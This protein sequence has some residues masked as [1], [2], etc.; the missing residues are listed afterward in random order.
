MVG[1]FARNQELIMYDKYLAMGCS[2]DGRVAEGECR[3]SVTDR[4][5][6]AGMSWIPDGAKAMLGLRATYPNGE[7][8]PFR[9]YHME[10]EDER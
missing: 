1:D 7:W 3:H 6:R 5:E 2:T 9:A 4:L 10:Q 8:A